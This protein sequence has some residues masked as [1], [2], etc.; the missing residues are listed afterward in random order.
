MEPYDPYP[1][2]HFALITV[3]HSPLPTTQLLDFSFF[4]SLAG[5]T[6]LPH[7]ARSLADLAH[8][9]GAGKLSYKRAEDSLSLD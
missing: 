1:P 3:D 7:A 5:V 8:G 2:F 6:V 4:Q 9:Y